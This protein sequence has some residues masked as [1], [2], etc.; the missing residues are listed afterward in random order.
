VFNP[1]FGLPL[2]RLQAMQEQWLAAHT[3]LASASSY[4]LNGVNLTRSS[5][6]D[7][8]RTLSQLAVAIGR[9]N[10][11]MPRVAYPVTRAR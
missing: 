2:A 4:S 9:A 5:L 11:S 1:F 3:A 8:E 7:V 6:P 10:G